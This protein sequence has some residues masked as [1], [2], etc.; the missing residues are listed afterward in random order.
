MTKKVFEFKLKMEKNEMITPY[1]GLGVFGGMWR[2]LGLD[3]EVN[4]L[5]PQPGSGAG[6]NANTYV[7]S[8]VMMMTGG[9]RVIEDIRKIKAD[10][11][12]QKICNM[13]IVPSADAMGNWLRRN[14]RA[15]EKC[16][17]KINANMTVRILRKAK[18]EGFT[19]D[20]DATEIEAEKREAKYT[21]NG[22]KGYMPMLGFIPELGWC[23]GYEFREGNVSPSERNKEFSR[24]TI[25]TVKKSGKKIVR[26]RSDSAAYQAELM[27][28]LNRDGIKYTITV[29]K[30]ESI[31]KA[32]KRVKKSE[33]IPLYDRDDIKTDR[34]YTEIIHS[35]NSSDHSFRII[36][37]R[38]KNPNMDLFE[39][40]EE[41]CY[42]GIATNYTEEE[43]DGQE[44]IH[45]HNNRGN[46]ENYNKEL[47]NGFGMD[48]MPC[49]EYGANAVWF[50][51][52]V[53][54][55][56][57]FMATKMYLFPENWL[58]KTIRT[59]RWQFIETSGKIVKHAKETVLKLCSTLRET[60]EIYKRAMKICNEL[61]L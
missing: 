13:G 50:G 29:S 60:Y 45:W 47:K 58:K 10:K 12:L 51:I 31:K 27:N 42:H 14:S 26:F 52:G 57:L 55:Y 9:G 34:E 30:D 53:L 18:E 22:V 2:S 44:V 56:N 24:K 32:I 5:F 59:I 46:S 19:L 16:L 25:K 4:T 6:F 37:M 20:I 1:A 11:G 54:A 41:Y 39:E 40:T 48:Y 7:N 8:M 61:Q 17:D 3:K 15:K 36:M 38:W 33:W 23:C 49:G 35:M 43:K 28:E 21:Y